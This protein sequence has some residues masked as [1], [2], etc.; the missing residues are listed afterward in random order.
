MSEE[1]KDYDAEIEKLSAEI[2]KGLDGLAKMSGAEK[3]NVRFIIINSCLYYFTTYGSI[4][5][6][7]FIEK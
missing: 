7:L 1:L 3:Q 5:S 4:S 6:A 2:H